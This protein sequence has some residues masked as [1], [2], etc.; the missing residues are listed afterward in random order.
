MTS[1][2]EIVSEAASRGWDRARRAAFRPREPASP[3]AL[4][5]LIE[6]DIIPRLLLNH[7]SAG[8]SAVMPTS[9]LGGVIP[10]GMADQFAA[11]TLTEEAGL[12]LARVEA[13]TAAGCSV[14]TIYL[15]LLAPAA[16]RLGSWWDEDACD[17][18]D[19]TMGLWRLQE[20]VNALA[21]LI[22]G[23]APLE[24]D[25]RRALFAP[26]PGEQHGLGAII[27]EEFFRRAGW[28]TWSA[29]AL[30]EDELV[31]LVAGREFDIVGLTVSVEQHL[32]TLGKAIA[33]VRRAS[34]NPDLLVLVGGRVFTERPDLATAVGA[35]GTAADG[36][37]ALDLAGRL[38]AQRD[39][40]MAMQQTG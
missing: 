9:A 7:R 8:I 2:F 15:E 12:L 31:A 36:A 19:V 6:A 24:G 10:N 3:D 14:E 39:A 13:L 11:A 1:M 35:D 32:G 5:R 27:V 26:A 34:R 22:P 33:S 28:Q 18:V 4:A 16:R 29:P 20:I 17:F 37:L 30:D 21:A 38:L 25:H 23:V 40:S